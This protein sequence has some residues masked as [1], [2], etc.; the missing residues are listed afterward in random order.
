MWRCKEGPGGKAW[1]EDGEGAIAI[2]NI[3]SIGVVMAVKVELELW[4]GVG[5]Q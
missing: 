3:E 4:W 2:W 5:Q 1:L